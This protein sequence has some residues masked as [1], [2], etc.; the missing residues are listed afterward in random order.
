MFRGATN[1][2]VSLIL[3]LSVVSCGSGGNGTSVSGS[4]QKGL[5]GN[6]S[7][8]SYNV[9]GLLEGLSQSQPSVFIPM[10]SPLLNNYD[11][12]LAQ[13][14]FFYHDDLSS[15]ATHPSQDSSHV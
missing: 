1:I 3:F 15:Q 11:L 2:A 8:L 9:A 7:V 14:D 6:F 10:I 12:V 13:E 5:E 4:V